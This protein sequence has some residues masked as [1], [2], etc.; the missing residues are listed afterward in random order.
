MTVSRPGSKLAL[1]RFLRLLVLEFRSRLPLL[2]NQVCKGLTEWKLV[3]DGLD[4]VLQFIFA[5][6]KGTFPFARWNG[7]IE[8][9]IPDRVPWEALFQKRMFFGRM[10]KFYLLSLHSGHARGWVRPCTVLTFRNATGV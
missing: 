3:C 10:A 7:E 4:N 8:R 1:Y 2:A 9:V 5:T 6:S